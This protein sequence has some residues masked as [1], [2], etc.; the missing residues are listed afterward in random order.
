LLAVALAAICLS[1]PSA[2]AGKASAAGSQQPLPFPVTVTAANGK[3]TL[4]R[5]P[6][7]IISLSPTATEDLFAIGAGRQ[8]IAVDDQSNYPAGAPRTK[9]SSYTP[10]PEAIAGYKPDL[11]VASYDANGLVRALER[12]HIPVLLDPGATS[13]AGAYSQI[14]QLGLAT[15]HRRAADSV[16]GWMQARIANTV[17][18]VPKPAQPLSFYHELSPSY[19]S[20][21]SKTFIGQIYGLFGLHDIADAADKTG[22]GYPQLSGEYIIAESPDLIILA[23]T[24]CCGQTPE[25]IRAR[26]GWNEISAVKSGNVVGVSDDVASRWGPRIVSFV[27][28]IAAQVKAAEAAAPNG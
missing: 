1:A 21:T 27:R 24:K 19:Y 20:A 11:V 15:G 23:D 10:N 8:V 22:A 13:L 9:L 12:L 7:R 26:P 17:R 25:T 2:L 3:V 4:K 16:V 28:I 18:S 5:R 6:V 14:K